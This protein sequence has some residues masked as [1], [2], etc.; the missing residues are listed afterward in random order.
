MLFRGVIVGAASGKVGAMVA[1]HNKGGQYMRARTTPT[2]PRTVYQTAVRDA[3]R[4]LSNAWEST[5]TPTQIGDWNVYAANVRRTN[6]LGDAT[7]SSGFSWYVGNNIPRL[8][9]ALARIDDAPTIFNTGQADLSGTILISALTTAGTISLASAGLPASPADILDN[10]S[11]S[12]LIFS[13]SRPFAGNRQNPA[14]GFRTTG[15]FL[16]NDTNTA[17]IVTLPFARGSADNNILSTCT[18]VRGDG[19]LATGFRFPG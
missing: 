11:T 5:L 1:S 14:G 10:D 12:A 3:V 6:R 16:G 19:R 15:V 18:V 4:S 2:N 7:N 9:A 8:Q 17:L 13:S